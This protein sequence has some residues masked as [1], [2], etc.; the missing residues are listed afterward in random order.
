MSL[1][2]HQQCQETA[3]AQDSYQPDIL[4]ETLLDTT[5]DKIDNENLI[6]FSLDDYFVTKSNLIYSGKEAIRVG[7]LDMQKSW[8]NYTN[9]VLNADYYQTEGKAEEENN[10][11]I[12]DL[13]FLNAVKQ[14]Y[15]NASV[16]MAGQIEDRSDEALILTEP[17][18]RIKYECKFSSS[19]YA[20]NELSSKV[21][22]LKLRSSEK[23][24]R[25][26]GPEQSPNISM[27]WN[28]EDQKDYED[29]SGSHFLEPLGDNQQA[30]STSY[31]TSSSNECNEWSICSSL[32]LPPITMLFGD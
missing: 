19:L 28:L 11:G 12:M 14:P 3:E 10:K 22:R 17:M 18:K 13:H 8:S 2:G 5:A 27:T 31:S 23:K 25:I 20:F 4:Y 6:K 29:Q 21:P 7:E 26:L 32:D 9:E 16:N 24:N 1:H 15:D 30:Q